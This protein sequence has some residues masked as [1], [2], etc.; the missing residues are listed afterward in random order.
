MKHI[1]KIIAIMITLVIVSLAVYGCVIDAQK[2]SWGSFTSRKTESYDGKYYAT[3]TKHEK[4]IKVTVY[5][6]ETDKE[7]YSFTPARSMD[8]WGICWESD[9]YNIWIQSGDIGV[10]CY[11]YTDNKWELDKQAERPADIISKYDLIGDQ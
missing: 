7:V 3:Q 10:Y 9:S 4:A 5:E 8:F 11:K 6:K 1:W 2:N